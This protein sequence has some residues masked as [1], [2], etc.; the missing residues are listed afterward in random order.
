MKALSHPVRLQI[1][2][3]LRKGEQNVGTIVKALGIQ[4]S[5]L[6]RHLTILRESGILAARQQGL[7]I[8]YKIDDEEIFKVLKPVRV[9]LCKRLRKT[10]GALRSLERE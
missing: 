3:F 7:L 8:Y 9:L 2:E 5:S 4:Q 6:S 1:I 10:E